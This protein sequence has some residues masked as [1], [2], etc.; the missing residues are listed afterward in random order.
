M[1]NDSDT[2][3]SEIPAVKSGSEGNQSSRMQNTSEPADASAEDRGKWK[4]KGHRGISRSAR[5][6]LISGRIV[7]VIRNTS[8]Y[9]VPLSEAKQRGES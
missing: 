9:P 6:F 3:P 8:P 1:E 5:I 2:E 7:R 4:N